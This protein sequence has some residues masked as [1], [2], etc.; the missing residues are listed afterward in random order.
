[1]KKGILGVVVLGCIVVASYWFWM[2]RSPKRGNY[3]AG[4]TPIDSRNAFVPAVAIPAT[5]QST[6]PA[7]DRADPQKIFEAVEATNVPINFWGKVVDQDGRPVSG[8]RVQYDYT[9]EHGNLSGVAWSDQEVRTGETVSD[10]EGLFSVLGLK[11]HDLG[12]LALK[13]PDYQ[14]RGK[15]A[16]SFDFYGST[17]SGKFVPD[18]HKP[19]VFTMVQKQR[20][21]PLIH[22]KGSLRVRGEGSP[23]RWNLWEGE[24]DPNGELA[25][26]FRREPAVL[27]RPGQ[28]ATW[29][30]DLE[31]IGG[32]IVEAPWDEDVRRAPESGYLPTIA[33]PQA[34]QKQG[35]PYWSFY[36]KTA[37]G[38][39][40]RIQVELDAY[41]QG[42]T[43]RCSITGDMNPRPGSRNLEPS[44]EE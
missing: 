36:V 35:V 16:L 13:H 37:D 23:E 28:A 38:R 31:I 44:E 40:G 8:V 3:T 21:E 6:R 20:L 7:S 42:A 33:Y 25:V 19:V 24:P 27:E 17:A 26:T 9:I 39:F 32:G 18:Q 14:F 2:M 10:K 15:G 12:I 22:V 43:A 41:S 4:R 1:M 34:E 5:V 11:G 29:S 30:A